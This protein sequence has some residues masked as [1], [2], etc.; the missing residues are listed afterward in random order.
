MQNAGLWKWFNGL[1]DFVV[2]EGVDVATHQSLFSALE[3][4]ISEETLPTENK[5]ETSDRCAWVTITLQL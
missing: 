5:L 2:L 4:I 3:K 1:V